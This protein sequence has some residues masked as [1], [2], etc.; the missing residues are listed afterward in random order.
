MGDVDNDGKI[1]FPEFA[2]LI[3]P[4]AG[5]KV[6]ILKKKLGSANE[7]A[8]AF[9]KFDVNGDGN[10]FNQELQNGLKSTGLNFTQ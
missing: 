3:I 7:V 4:S 5:E 8:A 10:I 9:K 1:S 2:K 6:S